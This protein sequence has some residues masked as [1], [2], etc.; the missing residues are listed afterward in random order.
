[1]TEQTEWR[2]GD[3]VVEE[4]VEDWSVQIASDDIE[5]FVSKKLAR[6]PQ[7]LAE[8]IDSQQPKPRFYVRAEAGKKP[9]LMERTAPG[10]KP[11]AYFFDAGDAIRCAQLLN[12][13]ES[14]DA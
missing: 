11:L 5:F 7:A 14:T 10:S 12:A 6:D 13:Q 3:V 4:D 1:M 9:Q 2:S 8:F